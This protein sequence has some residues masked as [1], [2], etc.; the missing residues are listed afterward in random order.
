M[1]PTLIIAALIAA[2]PALE[3]KVAGEYSNPKLSCRGQSHGLVLGG[4]H[5]RKQPARVVTGSLTSNHC[6]RSKAVCRRHLLRGD[7]AGA[8]VEGGRAVAE[9]PRFA[10]SGHP[11]Q[12]VWTAK[13]TPSGAASRLVAETS[14]R[15]GV[16]VVIYTIRGFC[17]QG[18]MNAKAMA[19]PS[20]P[21]G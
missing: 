14:G 16:F 12:R 1:R 15:N 19:E 18:P 5:R 21:D 11:P 6:S 20:R 2:S 9:S 17:G 4:A 13:P 8:I 7:A 3:G 10:R